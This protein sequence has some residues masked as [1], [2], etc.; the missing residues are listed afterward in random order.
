MGQYRYQKE[1]DIFE[2]MTRTERQDVIFE[3][4]NIAP[5]DHGFGVNLKMH[6]LQPGDKQPG[7][8][9]RV[10]FFRNDP[11]KDC[12]TISVHLKEE[13]IRLVGEAPKGLAT[14]AEINR[15]IEN[16]KKYRIPLWNMWYDSG[17]TQRELLQEMDAID[18]GGNVPP[19]GGRQGRQRS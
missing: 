12:I 7:H 1:E 9:P 8:G 3:M 10:K 14:R 15:L 5:E 18:R 11:R 4:A 19:R 13:G 17:M 6:I 16:V 2:P